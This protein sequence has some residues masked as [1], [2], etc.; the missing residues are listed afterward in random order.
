MARADWWSFIAAFFAATHRVVALSWAGMGGS[1]W[2]EQYSV[3]TMSDEAMTVALATGLF[4]SERKPVLVTHSFGAFASLLCAQRHGVRLGGVLTL[5]MPL[6]SRAQREAR[7]GPTLRSVFAQ[8]PTRVYPSLTDALARFRFAPEQPCENLFIADHIAR[9][10]LKEVPLIDGMC[11]TWRFDPRVSQMHPGD[12]ARS[13]FGAVCPVAMAWGADSA[14]VTP[15]V[16]AHGL[17]VAAPGT[18]RIA[19]PGARHHLMVDQPLALVSALRGLL[20][21]WPSRN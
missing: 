13:L 4:E 15:E 19:I 8:R 21:A 16:A 12:P 20:Q 14:L 10:S 3:E 1:R 11:R 17:S 7:R 5:D 6:L 9:T 2:R 18:P